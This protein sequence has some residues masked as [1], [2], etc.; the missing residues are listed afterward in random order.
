MLGWTRKE[1]VL[2]VLFS[3]LTLAW[4]SAPNW[5]GYAA[6]DEQSAFAGSYFDV[7][8]Y[9][10]HLAMM[11]SGRAG[12]WGYE[13]RFT[14]E[15]HRPAYTRLFYVLLGELSRP[16]G[17]EASVIFEIARW[18]FGYAALLS[19]YLLARRSFA[20]DVSGG[21]WLAFF[22]IVFGSGLGWLQRT[23]GW[24]PGQL[25]PIDFWLIDAY[26]LFSLSLFPHFAL[27]LA[28]MCL[29]W[30]LYLDFLSKAN[31]LRIGGVVLAALTVQL[32]DP[33]AFLVIDVAIA[34][35]ALVH[36]MM[37]GR[38][39][40]QHWWAALVIAV[41]Q[42][43]LLLYSLWLYSRDPVWHQY[44][45]QHATPSPPPIYYI[46]G[47]GLLWPF[48]LVGSARAVRQ[49]N[50][51]LVASLAWVIAAFALAYSPIVL[52]R[53]FLFGITIP[54][55][56]LAAAGVMDILVFA[57][58]AFGLWSGRQHFLAFLLGLSVCMTTLVFVP[59]HALYMRTRPE[60]FF[61]PMVLQEGFDWVIANTRPDDVILAA[62]R[63]SQLIAQ[64]TGRRVF[65][66][67]EME[68]VGYTSKAAEVEAFYRGLL[69][70]DWLSRYPIAWVVFGPYER[71]LAPGFGPGDPLELVDHVRTLD[72]YRTR[73]HLIR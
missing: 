52:Q 70:S 20:G 36:Q 21:K 42:I 63:T 50:I 7:A 26:V 59:A 45:L 57:S 29:G 15:P 68:T 1:L 54:L 64:Y 56:L 12:A 5:A 24:I 4:S 33:I 46:F 40:D 67:H 38:Q 51:I 41:A 39:G 48:A 60:G 71:S 30:M 44:A 23:T 49:R 16:F 72:I 25:T 61:Y 65:A 22:L 34:A 31:W 8:D 6:Q 27:S 69:P 2:F 62:P 18:V 13:I 11:Q 58:A 17:V 47:F 10:S 32:I 66:G 3:T 28:L 9:A 73:T 55:G 43:P 14:S 35:T 37:H 19:I 53:R